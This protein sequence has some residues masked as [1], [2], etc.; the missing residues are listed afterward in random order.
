MRELDRHR[1]MQKHF[2][3]SPHPQTLNLDN[4]SPKMMAGKP[5][6]DEAA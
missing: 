5:T 1:M 2:S 6:T 4:T 3:N